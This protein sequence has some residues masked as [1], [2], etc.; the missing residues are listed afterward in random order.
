LLL[1]LLL[2]SHRC[3]CSWRRPVFR[4]L[5]E[6]EGQGPVVHSRPGAGGVRIRAGFF[7]GIPF[8]GRKE[9]RR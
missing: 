7:M 8:Q 1:S 6:E 4:Q 2:S 3:A 5:V 9:L